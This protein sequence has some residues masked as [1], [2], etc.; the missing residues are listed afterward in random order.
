MMNK[1]FVKYLLFI[2]F[3][4]GF[5]NS[6]FSQKRTKIE[7]LNAN[8]FRSDK[9]IA[10]GARR[11]IGNVKFR[12]DSTI[13]K[14]DS[15][16]FYAGRNMF[17]AY[18]HVH[19][20][21]EGD[22]TIDVKSDFLRHNG[23]TK[24][25]HF[26]RNVVMRDTQIILYTDSLDYDIRRDIGYYLYGAT[27]VDSA[28]TLTSK[29]GYYYNNTHEV[30]FK[31]SVVVNHNKNEY[32]MFTDTLKYNTYSEIAYFYG[33][34][35]FYNDTN[36]MYAEYGWYNTVNDRTFFK[37]NALY[38][39]PKQSVEAD[40]LYYDRHKKYGIAHS[41]VVATDT[42]QNII[43]KGNFLEMTQE[44]ERLLITDSALIIYIAEGDSVYI[45]ADTMITNYDTSGLYREF[46]A[47]HHV[48]IFKS[49]FQSQADSLFFSMQDSILEFHGSPALWADSNQITATYIE[50]F[51]VNQKLDKFK[52]YDGGLIVSPQD[53]IYFNQV[54]G[55][56][57]V[58]YI[59]NNN[60]SKIDVFKHSITIYYPTDKYGIIG[61]NK[62][63]SDNIT[64]LLKH[65]KIHRI[66]YRQGYTGGMTPLEELKPADAK[67]R[68]FIWLETQRPKTPADVFKWQK[69][70][71]PQTRKPK[72]R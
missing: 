37:Q 24:M 8:Y 36:Y 22:N 68:N 69:L 35:E 33:P 53:T 29:K 19:L 61:A 67:V 45:H 71:I 28:S 7:I 62:S 54:K 16:Y 17:D 59:K 31:D 42:F 50:A 39:N 3:L 60:L 12:Q 9:N 5:T 30:F 34:T 51:I 32:Q 48:R 56:E 2:V 63:K 57:I 10:G 46:T 70:N 72:R 1:I 25:A 23:N 20:Y 44:P 11:L 27:I 13:M 55:K 26:R 18:G 38:T 52:L 43:V 4:F 64:I 65:N 14:C 58:G 66:V 40:S 41:N 15:A 49:N 6:S 47:F 21:K